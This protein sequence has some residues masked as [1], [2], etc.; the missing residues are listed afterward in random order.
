MQSLDVAQGGHAPKA[1]ADEPACFDCH[2]PHARNNPHQ[3]VDRLSSRRPD[4][5]KSR[6][7][8][9]A[10]AVLVPTRADD[11]SLCLTCHAGQEPFASLPVADVARIGSGSPPQTVVDAVVHHMADRGMNVDASKYDPKGT[12]VGN[13]VTCHMPL[14][15]KTAVFTADKAGFLQGDLHSHVFHVL[16]PR[17][18]QL[19]K[20][21][22]VGMSNSC[23]ACHPTAAGDPVAQILTDWATDDDGD[24]TFHGD[25]PRNIQNAIANA[26]RDGGQRCAGCHTTEGFISIQVKGETPTQGRVDTIVK[27]AIARDKGISCDACHGARADGTIDRT[28]RQPLRFPKADLCGRCHNNETIV[29]D[30]FRDAGEL[31]RHPMR[32][33]I[34][35]TA[36]AEVPGAPPYGNTVHSAFDDGCVTCHYDAES[37]GAT[38]RFGAQLATC[39]ACHLGIAS[40]NRPAADYDGDGSSAEGIQGEVQGLL[41]AVKAAL[42]VDPQ[43]TFSASSN[44]EYAGATDHKMTGASVAQKRAAFNWY[45]VSFDKS[46]GVHNALRTVQLLQRSYKELTG[47]DV[48]GAVIR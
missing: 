35:G 7:D 40:F 30:D 29:F 4:V 11:G 6:A 39:K 38:H 24:G 43:V 44:F 23:N 22:G 17:V 2:D 27:E 34:L 10:G 12:G 41:D 26:G 1:G 16:T 9:D 45:S 47:A 32:E 25:T 28:T 31:V 42:L 46:K 8:V 19:Y 21:G 14:V 37:P 33:M 36:G 20:D 3:I 5:T 15:A 13:C 48:P 18:S